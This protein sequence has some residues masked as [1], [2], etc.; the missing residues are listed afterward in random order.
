MEVNAAVF[1]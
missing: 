1:L